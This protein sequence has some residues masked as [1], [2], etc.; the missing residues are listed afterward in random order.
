MKITK[1]NAGWAALKERLRNNYWLL[2]SVML[3]LAFGLAL[4]S[5]AIDRR[6]HDDP[7]KSG[8]IY[9]GGADGARALLSTLAGATLTLAGVVFSMNLVALTMASAQFGPR[10]LY[11][12]VRDFGSQVTLG[13]FTAIFTFCMVVLREVNGE[14]ALTKPF[15]PHISVTIAGVMALGGLV[16][17]IY[18]VHH[19][20]VN[21]Q[22]PVV[23]AKVGRELEASIKREFDHKLDPGQERT[24][25]QRQLGERN[26]PDFSRDGRPINSPESG[27]VQTVDFPRLVVLANR[28]DL[29]LKL[30]LRPGNFAIEGTP[31][32]VAWPVEAVTEK[33]VDELKEC[34]GLGRRRNAAQDIEFVINELC[35]VGVRAM[36]P[37]IND[38]FTCI[39]CIDWLAAGLEELFQRDCPRGFFCDD[40]DNVRLI[41]NPVTHEGIMDAAFNQIR[42]FAHASPAVMIRMLEVYA[43]I[44]GHCRLETERSS[45]RKHTDMAIRA[46]RDSFSEIN[47]VADAEERYKKVL[48]NLAAG[49]EI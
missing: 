26:Q 49:S 38:P 48:A 30:L 35:E 11:N 21:I 12:F 32:V 23:V 34:I 31:L 44:A 7:W 37:S 2:P 20:A 18:F 27:Y 1:V 15:V 29:V 6:L 25:Y 9:M 46:C 13:T 43:R 41:W 10:L 5:L 42:Q 47:D 28:F 45:V 4:G 16:V 3:V 14:D 24:D 39:S 17:L 33:M 22:A 40:E 19:V 36:S 8:W